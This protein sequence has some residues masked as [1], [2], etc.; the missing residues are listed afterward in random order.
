MALPCPRSS[1]KGW[2]KVK[3]DDPVAGQVVVAQHELGG[4]GHLQTAGEI[5]G[6]ALGQVRR[7]VHPRARGR[8]QSRRAQQLGAAGELGADLARDARLAEGGHVDGDV[9]LGQHLVA[10]EV[11]QLGQGAIAVPRVAGL[12]G[13]DGARDDRE[14]HRYAAVHGQGGRHGR[15]AGAAH[16]YDHPDPQRAVR[17]DGALGFLIGEER[18]EADDR[19][20]RALAEE[21]DRHGVDV[22]ARG[23]VRGAPEHHRGAG[24]GRTGPGSRRQGPMPSPSRR[25]GP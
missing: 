13:G 11:G 8:P 2:A 3:L 9:R 1:V 25:G 7:R 12:Q 20:G 16:R 10:G 17:P 5:A 21:G 14:G 19:R 22:A 6:V 23:G 18:G 15:R 24:S 4:T